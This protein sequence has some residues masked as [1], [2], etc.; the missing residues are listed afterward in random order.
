MVWLAVA[1]VVL[2]S[3]LVGVLVA[4]ARELGRF[5]AF[6]R[7]RPLSS[8]AQLCVG[9]PLP[10]CAGL[11]SAVNAQLYA[12]SC[13]ELKARQ[14][15]EGLLEGLAGLSHDIRTPLAGAK[16]YIQLACAEEDEAERGKCLAMAEQRLD[17]MQEL[18]DQLFDYTRTLVPAD[19]PSFE[20]V[21]AMA[22]LSSVLAGRY[23]EF[24]D[25]GWDVRIDS[26]RETLVVE[27]DGG[28]LRRL[29]ENVVS[30]MLKHGAGDS[31]VSVNGNTMAF[32]N[33]MRAGDAVDAD[34]VFERFYRGDGSRNLPGAGLGLPVVRSLCETL[35][36]QAEA[37]VEDGCFSLVL[38]F[39]PSECS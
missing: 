27:S 14:D 2:A 11:A 15:E 19:P 34:M 3:A 38:Y 17:A 18:L 9:A 35:G 23:P 5:E 1:V 26:D 13:R 16:G 6:L 10:G 29:V 25:K 21:D 37:S 20:T 30:N 39:P 8:N 31:C 32:S 33:A 4:Y 12:W 36:M 24:A 28:M 22:V 7:N